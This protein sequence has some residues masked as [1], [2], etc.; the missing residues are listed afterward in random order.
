MTLEIKHF[1][2][3]SKLELYEMLKL[4]NEVFVV[5]QKCYYQDCDGHDLD[6][7][8]LLC[9]DDELVG[10][11]RILKPGVTY[12]EASIGR[13]VVKETHRSHKVG[14]KIMV[15]AIEY[16]EPPIRISAQEY[17]LSFYKSLGFV[18]VSE[19]YLEDDIPHVEMLLE[20]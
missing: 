5:E 19:M 6:A 17:L 18:Q 20:K 2:E 13:V 1:S 9:Y 10:Y 12:D 15:A 16:L 11:L 3:L 7:H 8:H 14:K 4:R